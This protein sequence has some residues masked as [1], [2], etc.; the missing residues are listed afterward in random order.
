[1]DM[2]AASSRRVMGCLTVVTWRWMTS[3]MPSW[4]ADLSDVE[5]MKLKMWFHMWACAL[6]RDEY[7]WFA[8]TRFSIFGFCLVW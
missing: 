1:M 3:G 5:L 8:S 7:S 2:A 4:M 6:R